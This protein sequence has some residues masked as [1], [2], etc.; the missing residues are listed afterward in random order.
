MKRITFLLKCLVNSYGQVI[1]RPFRFFAMRR[2]IAGFS[3]LALVFLSCIFGAASIYFMFGPGTVLREAFMGFD[4]WIKPT[5]PGSI[6]GKASFTKIGITFDDPQKA[7]DG[8]TLY[9]STQGTSATLIDMRGNRVHQWSRPFSTVWPDPPHVKHPLPDDSI[10]WF[11]SRVFPNG[12]LL[13]IYQ[14]DT[15]TPHGY[16][17]AKLDKDSNLLWAYSDNVHHDL[18]IGE[19]GR[20]YTLAHQV[21]TEKLEGFNSIV[22][23]YLG[24]YLVILSPEGKQLEKISIIGAIRQSHFSL[25][26]NSVRAGGLA[27]QSSLLLTESPQSECST[28]S[29]NPDSAKPILS[30]RLL[31]S[32]DVL[33]A[34]SVKVLTRAMT[35]N[36]PQLKEGQV[37]I[38]L[39]FLN[40]VVVLDVPTRKIVWA[41]QGVW[42][43]QHDAE[44]LDNGHL[45]LYDNLGEPQNTRVLEFDPKTSEYSWSYSNENSTVFFTPHRGMK[46]HL[47]NGNVLIVDADGGRLFE[48]NSAKDL[49]WEFGCSAGNDFPK[50]HAILTGAHRYSRSELNF[51][52]GTP[53][54][55]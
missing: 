24:D 28:Q 3:I 1:R 35:E 43:M 26:L 36:L 8:F 29:A 20:I 40:T 32:C 9:T 48:V 21:S 33:H 27:S 23:P 17:L 13:A 44:I 39:C 11:R 14:A 49:V 4:V 7:F 12:D 18:D 30:Q 6:P 54:R 42:R 41:A 47:P 38:S 37:L 2:I 16:G 25:M 53:V 15:D 19:D 51:L 22:P 55:P 50:A 10:H 46:Q 52:N 5:I 31:E 45:L 34:N